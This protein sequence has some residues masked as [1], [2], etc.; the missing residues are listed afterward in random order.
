MLD[1]FFLFLRRG[2]SLSSNVKQILH[3]PLFYRGDIV[4]YQRTSVFSL[5]FLVRLSA[6]KACKPFFFGTIQLDE[7]SARIF[8]S[9]REVL[10]PLHFRRISFFFSS[11]I[12]ER[13][14]FRTHFPAIQGQDYPRFF[15]PEPKI[16]VTS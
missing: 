8:P 13:L 3:P 11:L 15:P 10:A 2:A 1:V 5:L 16:S 4:L 14:W 7:R 6:T 9:E 12:L